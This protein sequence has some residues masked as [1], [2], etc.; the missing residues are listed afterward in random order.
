MTFGPSVA[1]DELK[2]LLP[3]LLNVGF[4]EDLAIDEP[5]DR[6]VVRFG[7][8]DS[9]MIAHVHCFHNS[10]KETSLCW[11]RFASDGAVAG[12]EFGMAPS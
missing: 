10:R 1:L 9:P 4:V 2:Q 8:Q 3:E 12:A 11:G 6:D 5:H 7:H